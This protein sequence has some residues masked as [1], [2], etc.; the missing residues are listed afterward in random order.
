MVIFD[1]IKGHYC[2]RKQEMK[3]KVYT[4]FAFFWN[5]K[6]LNALSHEIGSIL[7]LGCVKFWQRD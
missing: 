6:Q 5:V 1:N 4:Y 2:K 7:I 3:L